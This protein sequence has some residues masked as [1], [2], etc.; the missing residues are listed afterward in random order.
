MIPK[1]GW[2]DMDCAPKNG[3]VII[4][5]S[6]EWN[7]PNAKLQVQPGQWLCAMDGTDWRWRLPDRQGTTIHADAWMTFEEFQEA[8]AEEEQPSFPLSS[9]DTPPEFDL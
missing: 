7:N 3:S 4:V 2:K 1:N 9:D 5:R 8:Q 6:R